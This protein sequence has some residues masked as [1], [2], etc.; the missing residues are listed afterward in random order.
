MNEISVK[1]LSV[2]AEEFLVIAK[3]HPSIASRLQK[4]SEVEQHF[5]VA[6]ACLIEERFNSVEDFRIALNQYR[7]EKNHSAASLA[8]TQ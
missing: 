4:Y 6:M 3:N 7:K 1:E 2:R 8:G 5:I